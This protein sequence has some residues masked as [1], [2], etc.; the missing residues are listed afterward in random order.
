MASKKN[1]SDKDIKKKI[2]IGLTSDEIYNKLNKEVR[3]MSYKQLNQFDNISEILEPFGRV[4]ILYELIDS[5][6]HWVCLI[7]RGKNSVEFFDSYGG[8]PDSQFKYIHKDFKTNDYGTYP[9]LTAMLYESGYKIYYNDVKLQSPDPKVATC[10]RWCCLRCLFSDL[11]EYEF[12]RMWLKK[13]DPPD[14]L[15]TA[16][17]DII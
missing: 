17:Y 11:N 5:L 12:S 15:V 4:I 14:F 1:V 8:L 7:R 10:G 13:K 3:I 2:K 6:G 16:C 9:L